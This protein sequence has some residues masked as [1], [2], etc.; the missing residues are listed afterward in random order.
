MTELTA[1]EEPALR[2]Q[3][4]YNLR[5]TVRAGQPGE[6][7]SILIHNGIITYNT[8]HL[9]AVTKTDIEVYRIVTRCNFES[10]TAELNFHRFITDNSNCPFRQ[11]EANLFSYKMLISFIA[12]INGN[13]GI[14]QHC[15]RSCCGHDQIVGSVYNRIADFVQRT[16]YILVLHFEIRQGC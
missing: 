3:S 2:F 13:S 16:I 1:A 14:T 7:A 6:I 5:P 12:W 10:P 9:Q 11:G 15:F 4:R 8:Q